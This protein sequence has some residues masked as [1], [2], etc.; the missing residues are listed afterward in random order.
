MLILEIVKDA[1]PRQG[2]SH[3]YTLGGI[4]IALLASLAVYR[5]PGLFDK[6]GQRAGSSADIDREAW[7][8][9][10]DTFQP[11]HYQAAPYVANGYFGQ[12]LPAEGVGF[13]A[14]K[15]DDGSPDLNGMSYLL[16]S[17][18]QSASHTDIGV[19]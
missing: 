15:K 8:L 11:N 7:I 12:T 2:L 3:S 13:W 5:L 17:G 10:T 14:F 9:T 4:L 6:L 19:Q 16:E 18:K 1:R